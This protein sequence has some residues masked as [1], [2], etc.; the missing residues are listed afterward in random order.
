[1]KSK[2]KAFTLLEIMIAVAIF[3]VASAALVKNAG[4]SIRQTAMIRDKTI[5]FWIA[6]NEVAQIRSMP[7]SDDNFPGP[8]T[9]RTQVSMA[10]GQWEVKTEFHSTENELVRRVEVSVF[11]EDDLDVPVTTLTTFLGRY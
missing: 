2:S 9:N 5:A 3:A 1:M 8:G 6:E 7:R 11:R 4:L 10:G